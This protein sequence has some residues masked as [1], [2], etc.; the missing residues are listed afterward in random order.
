MLLGQGGPPEP[1]PPPVFPSDMPVEVGPVEAPK[2]A[3]PEETP[4]TTVLHFAPLSLF[5]THLSF[6]LE[7][8]I[9][10]SVTVSA[11]IGGSLMLQVGGE[12]GLR[13]Y[14]GERALQGP[15]LGVQGAVFYFS[16]V[17]VVLLGPGVTGGYTFR[18]KG[19]LAMSI[20]GGLQAWFQPTSDQGLR[21]LGVNPFTSVILLPGFQRPGQGQW[22]AQPTL[23]FTVGPTF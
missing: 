1:S 20:G 13:T 15:F 12:V 6:E 17:P 10:E 16:A 7:K 4:R 19:N 8:A 9:S 11:T 14:L 2:P 5:A 18:P 22:G 23:R 3:P 21:V